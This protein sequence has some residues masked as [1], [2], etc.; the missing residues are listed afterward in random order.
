MIRRPSYR[1]PRDKQPQ[2]PPE[3]KK[4]NYVADSHPHLTEWELLACLLFESSQQNLPE[5]DHRRFSDEEARELYRVLELIHEVGGDWRDPDR[6]ATFVAARDQVDSD[7]LR[8]QLAN[9]MIETKKTT[10]VYFYADWLRRDLAQQ[11]LDRRVADGNKHRRSRYR[12]IKDAYL[13]AIPSD[14]GEDPDCEI[15]F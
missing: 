4:R 13:T 3:P 15:D 5:W 9:V 7:D 10:Y 1:P 6:I 2:S 14:L 12:K 11:S 8:L